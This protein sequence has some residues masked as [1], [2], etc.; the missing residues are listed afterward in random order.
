M[1]IP[2]SAPR[3]LWVLDRIGGAGREL[4]VQQLKS[5]DAAFRALAVRILRRHGEEYIDAIL[6]LATIPPAK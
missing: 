4:V 5:E 2:T 1:R 6:P 3:A